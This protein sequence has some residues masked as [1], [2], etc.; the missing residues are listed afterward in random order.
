MPALI[1]GCAAA[2][3]RQII[4][5][6][7]DSENTGS[8]RLHEKF[9]FTRVGLLPAVGYKFGRWVDSVLMQ[10]DLGEARVIAHDKR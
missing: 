10:R 8:I 9:G 3:K 6:I 5:V 2:G 1:E 7:G 4:A